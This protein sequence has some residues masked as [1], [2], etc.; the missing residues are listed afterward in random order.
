MLAVRVVPVAEQ[1]A[2]PVRQQEADALA[3]V[4][5]VLLALA[6]DVGHA[7]HDV[8]EVAEGRGGCQQRRLLAGS[9]LLSPSNGTARAGA[10]AASPRERLRPRPTRLVGHPPTGKT[11]NESTSVGRST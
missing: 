8:A 3:Q 1:V 6:L 4:P 7:Q 11:G 5:A 2:D 9:Q 10:A